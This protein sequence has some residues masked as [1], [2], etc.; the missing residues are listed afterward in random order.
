MKTKAQIE[1]VN[2]L[3]IFIF[4]IVAA[5]SLVGFYYSFGQES[6]MRSSILAMTYE[7]EYLKSLL[8][9][10]RRY[11]LDEAMFHTARFGGMVCTTPN[12]RLDLSSNF[13]FCD[14][15]DYLWKDG[16]SDGGATLCKIDASGDSIT[17]GRLQ[18]S[19]EK[20]AGFLMDK[21][22]FYWIWES[23]TNIP[24]AQSFVCGI[25]FFLNKYYN[26]APESF[27]E[28]I[29]NRADVYALFSLPKVINY[30][31]ARIDYF[32][33]EKIIA[34]FIPGDDLKI[35]A[36]YT[37]ESVNDY[38]TFI[39]R[40]LGGVNDKV[41]GPYS[42]VIYND[43][44]FVNLYAS[45]QFFKLYNESKILSENN[46]VDYFKSLDVPYFVTSPIE[47]SEFTD[48]SCFDD[49]NGFGDFGCG[50]LCLTM[51]PAY[52]GYC[53]NSRCVC[54][55]GKLYEWDESIRKFFLCDSNRNCGETV[56]DD[57]LSDDDYYGCVLKDFKNYQKEV[58]VD[59][60]AN[61]LVDYRGIYLKIIPY[62]FYL[63]IDSNTDCDPY[64]DKISGYAVLGSSDSNT[65]LTSM[66]LH[67]LYGVKTV[68]EVALTCDE[69]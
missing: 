29:K 16:I 4:I 28:F 43:S 54:K 1:I 41:D 20:P 36:V 68:S 14:A 25:E 13:V 15:D 33:T 58:I 32:D 62:E 2:T 6:S 19:F 49:T 21:N 51:D 5:R 10:E 63:D 18:K 3:A 53:E 7:A 56:C 37:E 31:T 34:S 57:T 61:Q 27:K 48:Y 38:Y 67:L 65:A 30:S 59:A 52:A 17:L 9:E 44:R 66:P 35:S 47:E 24:S 39:K 11:A 23:D 8:D 12:Y 40:Y 45:T 60:M 69:V 64:V 22:A 26:E 55:K 50:E 42:Y 46:F